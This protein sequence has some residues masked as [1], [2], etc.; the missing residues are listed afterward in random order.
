[1]AGEAFLSI[2]GSPHDSDMVKRDYDFELFVSYKRDR[3][4]GGWM[5]KVVDILGY[6]LEQH[7]TI[8]KPRIF[9]DVN[10][11]EEGSLWPEELQQA[12]MGSRCM[13]CFWSADYF[14]GSDW[15]ISE[16]R[17]F[18]EREGTLNLKPGSLIYP[19]IRNDGQSLPDNVKLY[20]ANN[21]SDYA[22]TVEAF[23]AT[24]KAAE[25]EDHLERIAVKLAAR[26]NAA[27]SFDANFPIVK[28]KPLARP[29]FLP[30]LGGLPDDIRGFKSV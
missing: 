5:S 16:W 21:L 9:F 19:V 10:S 4:I 12:V 26:M 14:Y 24:P 8:C 1:M 15:C 28:A 30:R 17:S 3:R 23:W 2:H 29:V 25:L 11:I 13:L 22:R 27:P 6:H 20:Q 7:F 18:V